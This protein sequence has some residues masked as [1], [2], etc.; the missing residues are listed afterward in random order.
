MDLNCKTIK[1]TLFVS[2]T[3]YMI[4]F[5]YFLY[6]LLNITVSYKNI[7]SPVTKRLAFGQKIQTFSKGKKALTF[8]EDLDEKCEDFHK[9]S[10]ELKKCS[11]TVHEKYGHHTKNYTLP[12]IRQDRCHCCFPKLSYI[13]NSNKVCAGAQPI[14]IV[15]FITSTYNR[16]TRRDI[17]RQTWAS[18]EAEKLYNTRH[19]FLFGMSKN[20]TVNYLIK[21]ENNEF[22]DMVQGDFLDSYRN[23]TY[24]TIFGIRWAVQFCPNAKFVMKTDDDMWVNTRHLVANMSQWETKN[25]TN[26]LIGNCKYKDYPHRW[27]TSKWYVTKE[28]YPHTLY[29]GLC[30][31]AGY[32][33]SQNLSREIARISRNIPYF[34]LEDVYVS[35]CIEALGAP[36]GLYNISRFADARPIRYKSCE[37]H[38][39]YTAHN[40][41]GY[42]MLNEWKN[43]TNCLKHFLKLSQNSRFL[44]LYNRTWKYKND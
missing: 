28:E 30:S 44:G 24:K 39:Q 35:L 43:T 8:I 10:I 40:V 22:Q 25:S 6:P 3:I 41:P 23:L 42:Q 29:P 14:E 31:G 36:Y 4:L 33:M 5:G 26:H 27:K 38:G 2:L 13:F 21:K 16:R 19:V 7:I 12:T 37:I 1:L 17:L 18:H 32:M 9:E 11:D 20:K 34:F 15:I